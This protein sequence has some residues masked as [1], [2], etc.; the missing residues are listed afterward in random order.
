MKVI[1]YGFGH[2]NLLNN[3]YPKVSASLSRRYCL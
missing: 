3:G 1:Y 2:C